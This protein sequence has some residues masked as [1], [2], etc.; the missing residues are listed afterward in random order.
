MSFG[1]H[2]VCSYDNT[3]DAMSYFEGDYSKAFL[4][5][6]RR[7]IVPTCLAHFG[8][9][10]SENGGINFS[11]YGV[12]LHF[13]MSLYGRFAMLTKQLD[14]DTHVLFYLYRLSS[15]VGSDNMGFS[16]HQWVNLE[17]NQYVWLFN[18]LSKLSELYFPTVNEGS[19]IFMRTL[20][21]IKI[22]R[23]KVTRKENS[24]IFTRQPMDHFLFNY[25]DMLWNF[26]KD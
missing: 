18:T 5:K 2:N 24:V 10:A 6:F 17:M 8:M 16:Y 26:S 11:D 20:H 23:M 1:H 3:L 4:E 7:T 12:K 22:G 21:D 14:E 15:G 13:S 19:Y 25:A 9:V